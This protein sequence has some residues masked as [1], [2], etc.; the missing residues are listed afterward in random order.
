MSEPLNT[1]LNDH[2]GGAQVAIQ[3]L[4]AM[5]DQHDNQRFREFA[6]VLLPEIQADDRTLRS[7]A[8]KIGSGPSA[9]KQIGGWLLEKVARLKL[10]HTGSTDFEM[11]ESLELLVLGIHG[12]LCLWKA[13]QEASKLDSRLREY[14]FEELMSRAQQQYDKVESQRLDLAQTVLSPT[15]QS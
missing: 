2:L 10:G 8:E 14:D 5:R 11:F 3:I 12:K 7:I 9:V 15:S 13:L 4:E 6:G 1:Y